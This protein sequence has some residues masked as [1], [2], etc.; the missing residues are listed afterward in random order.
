M[1]GDGQLRNLTQ[2]GDHR[3]RIL[4]GIM[5]ILEGQRL[6]LAR[7]AFLIWVGTGTSV[8]MWVLLVVVLLR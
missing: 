1:M 5:L 8:A 4:R 6:A 7:L 3:A 2:T